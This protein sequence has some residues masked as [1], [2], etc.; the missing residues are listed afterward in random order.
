MPQTQ[1]QQVSDLMRRPQ[2]CAVSWGGLGPWEVLH[3]WEVLT[4]QVVLPPP[5]PQ[6]PD[7]PGGAGLTLGPGLPWEGGQRLVRPVLGAGQASLQPA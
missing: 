3:P 1:G 5:Y 6:G 2:G 7:P 4:P